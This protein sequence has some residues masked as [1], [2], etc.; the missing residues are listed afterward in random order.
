METAARSEKM[1]DRMEKMISGEL[2]D[3]PIAQLIGLKVISVQ[4]GESH[5]EL[6]AGPQHF[7]PMGTLHGGVLC[8]LADLA[9]GAAYA[10]HFGQWR[11]IHDIGTENQFPQARLERKVVCSG[12]DRESGPHHRHG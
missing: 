1:L 2:P 3:P 8:D 10:E 4:P 5:L 9:M 11:N 7:N 6:D 12:E